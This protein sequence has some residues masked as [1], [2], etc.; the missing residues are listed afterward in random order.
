[1]GGIQ[2]C[3]YFHVL[4]TKGFL[5]TALCRP[6]VRFSSPPSYADHFRWRFDP[7]TLRR[8]RWC[9]NQLSY[10]EPDKPPL[11]Q[12]PSPLRSLPTT[13]RPTTHKTSSTY[14][15]RTDTPV[16]PSQQSILNERPTSR[17]PAALNRTVPYI[18]YRLC[19]ARLHLY[20]HR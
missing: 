8:P 20:V 3:V 4:R 10:G 17:T 18:R 2:V 11:R 19:Y 16:H 1:M 14:S 12:T 15:I 5:A 7:A 6:L 9:A 13:P